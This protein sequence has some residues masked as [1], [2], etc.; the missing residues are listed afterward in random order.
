VTI[1]P[2]SQRANATSMPTGQYDGVIGGVVPLSEF[3][4]Q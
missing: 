3:L 1:S 2:T 4:L